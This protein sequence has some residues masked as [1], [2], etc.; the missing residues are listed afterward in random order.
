MNKL[1]LKV[2]AERVFKKKRMWKIGTPEN[3]E[4]R[5]F[6]GCRGCHECHPL[7]VG[8]VAVFALPT[9]QSVKSYIIL[10]RVE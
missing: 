10:L 1:K 8:Q 9:S 3:S 2:K 7:G 6:R 5:G 4:N